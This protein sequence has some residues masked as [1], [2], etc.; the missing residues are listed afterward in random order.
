MQGVAQLGVK[1]HVLRGE[2]VLAAQQRLD[3]LRAAIREENVAGVFIQIEVDAP[4]QLAGDLG[5]ER[6]IDLRFVDLAGDH[7]RDARFVDEQ[8]IGLVHQGE[9]KRPVDL[10]R[11]FQ[12]EAVAQVIEP[13]LLHRDVGDVA[14]IG[15]LPI[16][17]GHPLLDA[18]GGEPQPLV[19][20]PHP[21]GIAPGQVVVVGEHVKAMAGQGV[22]RHGATAAR[23]LPSPVCI[24]T[25]LPSCMAMPARS[26]TS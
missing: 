1:A 4:F 25:S 20:R 6:E 24:S 10:V 26:C 18:G 11:F 17:R 8:R 12:T 21:G 9:M 14:A 2:E 13:R 19:D 16:L 7:Q 5:Q 15:P 22:E 3:P 23:V